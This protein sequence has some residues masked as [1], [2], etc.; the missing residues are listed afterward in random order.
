MSAIVDFET[1]AA[2]LRRL[3]QCEVLSAERGMG[4]GGSETRFEELA[5]D[6]FALQFEYNPLYRRLCEARRVTPRSV[7]HWSRVPSVPTS[8]F[9]ELELSCLSPEQRTAVFYSSGTTEQRPS[10][11]FHN[12][13]S[14]AIYE[15]SLLPWFERHVLPT[16]EGRAP[17]VPEM[18]QVSDMGT[19]GARPSGNLPPRPP[20]RMVALTPSGAQAPHSSLAH[21][22]ETVLREFGSVESGFVGEVW[23]DGAWTVNSGAALDSLGESAV[24]GQPVVILG[25][26]FLFLHLLD[27]MAA[28][29]LCLTLPPGSRAL[30]T[31]GY[32]GRSR[33]LPKAELHALMTQRLGIPPAHIVCEYGMSELSSQGYEV[34]SAECEVRNGGGQR[35]SRSTPAFQFPPWARVQ[36]VSPET[37]LE[38]AE[39]ETGLIRV[40]D[41]ANV[42]SVMAIQTED[43]GIRRGEGFE[44]RGRA[45]M[46]EPRGCSLMAR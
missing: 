46:S 28:R 20:I 2:R 34:R 17:R 40:F 38:V 42:Y 4:G 13:Q 31:G 7:E 37:G 9:K 10:R 18:G 43:L 14:L 32:K 36:I 6:L 11:H 30:E 41:L 25:T 8:A 19:R 15:A 12:A 45:V 35:Q 5:L 21:M 44:L 39:G 33:T 29:N 3:I 26:A 24:S 1:F 16:P 23:Q 27:Y 22:F